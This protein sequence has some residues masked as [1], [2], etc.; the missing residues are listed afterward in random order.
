MYVAEADYAKELSFK[1]KI[2]RIYFTFI[3]IYLHFTLFIVLY[4]YSSHT[5]PILCGTIIHTYGATQPLISP[6][7]WGWHTQ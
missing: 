4:L 1:R 6:Q 3:Y 5:V 2:S 7:Q